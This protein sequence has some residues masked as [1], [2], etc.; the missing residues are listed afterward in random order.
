MDPYTEEKV[1]TVILNP[2]SKIVREGRGLSRGF[3]L[4]E[5]LVVITIIGILIAL[6]LPAVQAAREA[7]R[8]LQCANNFKQ[9]GLAMH[10][11]HAAKGCFPP[12]MFGRVHTN[13]TQYFYFGWAV[14][15]L[16]YM[17]QDSR[18]NEENWGALYS[19]ADSTVTGPNDLSNDAITKTPM[20][21][22]MCVSDPQYGEMVTYHS[23]PGEDA[24]MTNM[25]GV[26]DTVSIYNSSG[27]LMD[28]PENDGIM[29][30][31]YPC[32]VA[33]I[34]DGT[35]NTLM[36]GEVTGAGAG[37]LYGH[38]WSC[39][40]ITDTSW[41]INGPNTLPGGGTFPTTNPNIAGFSSFHPG[42]CNFMLADGSVSFITENVSQNVLIA[43]T[44]RNGVDG[45][46][47][48]PVIISGPP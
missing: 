16:P 7:A 28:F 1:K 39:W 44:T 48:D 17:E 31:N 26:S 32:M 35:S 45:S 34:Q 14:Y 9:A 3:T 20:P 36:L 24:A 37:S 27:V 25:A 47:I 42:G 46:G 8:R 2:S 15:I 38:F 13:P 21:C 6:L 12:G 23:V 11:Y 5:L 4:V 19:Y 29:G 41:G 30:G 33:N 18:Y 43:L 40:N 22:Y 10:N